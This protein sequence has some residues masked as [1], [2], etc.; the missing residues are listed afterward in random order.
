MKK[1]LIHFIRESTLIASVL[2]ALF[3]TLKAEPKPLFEIQQPPAQE[4]EVR[5]VELRSADLWSKRE[6]LDAE[7][8]TGNVVF[9]HEVHICIVIVHT[10]I[11][12]PIH[13]RLL[14]M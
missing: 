11:N 6:G 2:F 9:Y 13:L 8:L 1:L 10:Y 3:S 12:R 5:V 14:V 7:V 4:Q